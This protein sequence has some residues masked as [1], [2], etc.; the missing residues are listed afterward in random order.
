MANTNP[1]NLTVATTLLKLHFA[2]PAG[3]LNSIERDKTRGFLARLAECIDHSTRARIQFC[4]TWILDHV[5]ISSTRVD[6]LG[7]YLVA[8]SQSFEPIPEQPD[9]K[10]G[11]DC[12]V[13]GRRLRLLFIVYDTLHHDKFHTGSRGSFATDIQQ[14]IPA[15]V[16]LAAS[17][18]L[19]KGSGLEEKFFSVLRGFERSHFWGINFTLS[20]RDEAHT[21]LALAQNSEQKPKVQYTLPQR[22]GDTK[23]AW[24]NLPVGNT[25]HHLLRNPDEPIPV[26]ALRPVNFQAGPAD[27]E[28]VRDVDNFM[29]DVER[30]YNHERDEEEAVDFDE[31]GQE[32]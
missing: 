27:P 6:H 24:Y 11:S 7:R 10:W 15:L 13:N 16:K 31:L 26:N 1:G 18:I 8:L 5:V 21:A 23:T 14:Y 30:M 28:L 29:E 25:L 9:T 2:Q 4:K 32:I 3:H 19:V 17:A 20:T 22:H 12:T